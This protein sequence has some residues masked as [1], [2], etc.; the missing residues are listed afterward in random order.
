MRTNFRTGAED[1]EVE[2]AEVP[3]TGTAARNHE[4]RARL[5]AHPN[6]AVT[7]KGFVAF[8]ELSDRGILAP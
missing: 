3:S 5:A 6:S 7:A 2:V 8:E 1:L 4:D